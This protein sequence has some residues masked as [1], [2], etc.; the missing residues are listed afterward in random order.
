MGSTCGGLAARG[1]ARATAS[2][3]AIGSARAMIARLTRECL[4]S[5]PWVST[6]PVR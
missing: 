3:E 6:L 1:R 2:S 4:G 5:K